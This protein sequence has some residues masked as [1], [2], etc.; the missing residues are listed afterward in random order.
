M[1][2]SYRLVV[3]G[4][5]Y[6]HASGVVIKIDCEERREKSAITTLTAELLDPEWHDSK[7]IFAQTKDPA[8][9]EVPVK[10]YLAK[11]GESRADQVL[12]FDGKLTT[13]AVGYPERR[14]L[15][16]TAHD[17]SID[18]RRKKTLNTFK[19]K[20]A[21]QVAQ[22]IA[23]GYG[24]T[25]DTSQVDDLIAGLVVREIDN[26]L[27]PN[28]SD[29]DHLQRALS[30]DGFVAVV[31]G[32]KLHVIRAPSVV[33]ATTMERGK[34]PVTSLNVTIQHVRGPGKQGDV[35]GSGAWMDSTGT[36]RAVKGTDAKAADKENAPARTGRAPIAGAATKSGGMPSI[37]DID[38]NKPDAVVKYLRQRKDAA[39]LTLMAAPDLTVLNSVKL[40]GWGGKV[41]GTWFVEAVRNSIVGDGSSALTNVSLVRGASDGAKKGALL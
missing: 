31:R 17:K 30:A 25:V 14:V 13:M 26:G 2:A 12:V 27:T 29:W 1:G 40:K 20:N 34:F 19:G 22:A 3:D 39:Q 8:F 38:G 16:L 5:E 6:T 23:R 32:T 11:A 15:T 4:K 37:E 28:L 9:T 18:A 7:S 41:D 24:F 35:R 33:Y 36:S 21:V 10:L